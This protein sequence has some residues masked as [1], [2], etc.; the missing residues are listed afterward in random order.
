MFCTHVNRDWIGKIPRKSDLTVK[1][2][3]LNLSDVFYFKKSIVEFELNVPEKL[4]MVVSLEVF[5]A[6]LDGALG[7]LKNRKPT[8]LF[9]ATLA[10]LN[11]FTGC[12]SC[13][14]LYFCPLRGFMLALLGC[15]VAPLS[16][17]M[18][19]TLGS[20]KRIPCW[21]LAI[22][23][24]VPVGLSTL[25]PHPEIFGR[26]F[27]QSAKVCCSAGTLQII[28]DVGSLTLRSQIGECFTR[29]KV[30]TVCCGSDC[31]ICVMW[32]FNEFFH[33]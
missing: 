17:S 14:G 20:W 33:Y 9:T 26:P 27:L 13:S 15:L 3:K 4:W 1:T 29:D 2:P 24:K 11:P 19:L 7:S 18:S 32:R 10:V 5:K 12:F 22:K 6:T 30:L 21:C 31:L 23:H 16:R 28:T 8:N 25:I